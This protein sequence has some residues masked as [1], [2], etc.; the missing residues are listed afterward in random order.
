[1]I[2]ESGF[3]AHEA[4]PLDRYLAQLA[5]DGR[6]ANT[7]EAYAADL[8]QLLAH[9]HAD[10]P[11]WTWATLEPEHLR[12]HRDDLARRYA[13]GSVSRKLA[14]AR[15][16][17]AWLAAAG[18]VGRDPT[19]GLRAPTQAAWTPRVLTT[20]ELD[21]LVRAP[22]PADGPEARR[23][24]ALLR[25][26]RAT[27][28]RVSEVVAL[29]LADLD[30]AAGEVQVGRADRERDLPLDPATVG[31][32]RRYVEEARP[33]LHLAYRPG[34]PIPDTPT[35]FVNYRGERMTRQGV[36]LRLKAH[37]ARA[38]LLEVS[39]AAVRH[40][41]AVELLRRR[42]ALHDVQELLG[43]ASAGTTQ[44]YQRLVNP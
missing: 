1:M 37:A 13:P 9:L 7:V 11:G 44:R 31:A 19:T 21:A 6:S 20:A 27:G 35:L 38:G 28:A 10:R 26:L 22:D 16:F 2:T 12:G 17:F 43:H 3:A 34:R 5:A 29:D 4:Q 25:L 14:S 42:T 18:L 24:A 33:R 41:C 36:W 40:S 30:F 23:D 15:S 39:A 32:L 8:R